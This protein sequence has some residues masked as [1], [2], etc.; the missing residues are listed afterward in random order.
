MDALVANF[1][2]LLLVI[3]R[4]SSFFVTVPLFSYR[5]IPNNFKIGLAVLLSLLVSAS[6][7]LPVVE[8]DDVYLML[9]LKEA[10]VG[11]SIGLIAF[12]MM[13]AIQIAGGFIDFQ[14]GFAIVNVIDPQTGAQGPIMGQ[15]FYVIA[16]LLLLTFNGHHL[17]LDGIYY[18]YKIVPITSVANF[19]FGSEHLSEYFVRTFNSM[20]IIAFQMAAPVVGTLFLVDLALGIVARTVPQLNIFVVGLPLKILV[21]LVLI[22]ISMS[23]F[24]LVLNNLFQQVIEVMRGLMEIIGGV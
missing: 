22:A 18:S 1:P 21:S 24:S 8:I 19:P 17:L 9:V 10:M 23:A 12:I 20:F 2:T 6:M 5:T 4:I 15:Y 3:T 13:S 14:M 7:K 11:L 16:L